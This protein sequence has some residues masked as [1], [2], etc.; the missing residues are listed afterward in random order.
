M[1][2]VPRQSAAPVL[3]YI[4]SAAADLELKEQLDAAAALRQ[5]A[6][7][8]RELHGRERPAGKC[9]P[10]FLAGAARHDMELHRHTVTGRG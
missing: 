6:I 10:P 8:P 1:R 5:Q 7:V 9:A 3:W 2:S 4:S